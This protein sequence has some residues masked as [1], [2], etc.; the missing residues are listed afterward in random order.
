M[1]AKYLYFFSEKKWPFFN[2]VFSL[3]LSKSIHRLFAFRFYLII[4]WGSSFSYINNIKQIPHFVTYVLQC[5]W[6]LLFFFKQ[7]DQFVMHHRLRIDCVFYDRTV[8]WDLMFEIYLYLFFL[9]KPATFSFFVLSFFTLRPAT[10]FDLFQSL[11]FAFSKVFNFK[12]THTFFYFFLY[13][14]IFW[15]AWI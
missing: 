4:N 5:A 9:L 13:F 15:I 7:G 6:I 11:L 1:I 2:F 8:A 3:I 12:G 14:V 10:L